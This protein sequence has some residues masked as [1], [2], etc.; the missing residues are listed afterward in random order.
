MKIVNPIYDGGGL[1][2]RYINLLDVPWSRFYVKWVA[3][4]GHL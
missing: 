4:N 1:S 3:N 2:S